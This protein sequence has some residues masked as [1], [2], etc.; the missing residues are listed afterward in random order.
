MRWHFVVALAA[1]ASPGWAVDPSTTVRAFVGARLLPV[2]SAEIGDGVLIVEG[3]RIAAVGPR[4]STPIPPA[5]E[6]IEVSGR[7]IIPGLVDTHS[8]VGG[9]GGGDGSGP[10]QPGVRVLDSIDVS[11]PGF[12]RAVAGGITTLNVMPGSG[13][14]SSGQTVYLRLTGGRGEATTIDQLLLRDADGRPLGG[15]KMA[16]GTNSMRDAPFPGTRGRSAYLLRTAFLDAQAYREKLASLDAD[17]RP[18]RDLDQETLVEVLEGRRTVH[19]HTHR[20]DDIM[21]VL[22]L[23]EEFGLSVVLHHLSEGWRVAEELAAAGVAASIIVVDAPGG[24]L[25]A[26]ELSFE[27]GA[28]LAAAGVEVAIHTDDWITDSRLFLRS[29]AL[30]VRGG[31]SRDQALAAL[32]LAGAR[33]LGVEDRVGSLDVG[34][35]AD[36]VILDGDPFAAR[37]RVRETWV[38]GRRVFDL[39]D[40]IDAL[41]AEGGRGAGEAV[42][43]PLCDAVGEGR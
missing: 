4:G 42:D 28:I 43:P 12:R 27:T 1:L 37:T 31:M 34:K 14:L 41:H 40:P 18:E 36:F 21:S 24:K 11:S 22:R 25:E 9:V 16:N 19:F 7:T 6:V 39:T 33:M 3:E 29:G 23:R 5:A 32:S 10:I 20:A 38:G 17:K 35:L 13:L 30:A 8:H 26:R 2:S 15:L